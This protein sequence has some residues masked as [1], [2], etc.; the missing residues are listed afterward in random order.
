MVFVEHV[1][2][3]GLLVVDLAL[4]AP[5]EGDQGG[6]V[7]AERHECR[8][9]AERART[10]HLDGLVVGGVH[11][12]H[13]GGNTRGRRG[14]GR[15]RADDLTRHLQVEQLLAAHAELLVQRRVVAPLPGVGVDGPLQDDVVRGGVDE[16]AGEPVSDVARRRG[17]VGER[18]VVGQVR[19][20]GAL[21]HPAHH[22]LDQF[23]VRVEEGL[24]ASDRA[25]AHTGDV[26]RVARER[27][28]RLA[29]GRGDRGPQVVV[30]V[31]GHPVARPAHRA[32][33]LL[34]AGHHGARGV[35]HHHLGALRA[36][37]DA[38][39][40]R[41]SHGCAPSVAPRLSGPGSRR[42]RRG[43]ARSRNRSPG[44][45][46]TPRCPSGRPH[47]PTGRRGCDRAHAGCSRGCCGCWR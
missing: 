34:G 12:G 28:H 30:G 24:A 44:W 43:C 41:P 2:G 46:G 16:A 45:R 18:R 14:C 26:G 4:R 32:Q 1:V 21:V 33:H 35:D 27:R 3:L 15:E 20:I 10:E 7:G 13:A 6:D 40:I 9:L 25:D 36:A 23:A 39:Q 19:P 17:G 5:G 42:R 11:H 38:D 47:R 31:Q 8:R 22:R 37:V 29:A